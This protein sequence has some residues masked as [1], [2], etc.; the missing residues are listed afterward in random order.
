VDKTA[1]Q[2]MLTIIG[3]KLTTY[4][5]LAEQAVDR[6]GK[7]LRRKLPECRSADTLLPGSHGLDEARQALQALDGLSDAGVERLL[8]VYGGRARLLAELAAQEPSL[9]P[10][11]DAGNRVL[12]AEVALAIREEFAV[13]LEDIVFRRLMIGLDADQG[14]PMYGAVA[15]I[16]ALELDWDAT[17]QSEQLAMLQAYSDSLRV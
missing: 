4:R 3:G 13:T 10:T 2:G 6:V 7:L 11:L 8:A 16:A 17:R 12:A 1:A 5:H 14:R 15:R 9:R